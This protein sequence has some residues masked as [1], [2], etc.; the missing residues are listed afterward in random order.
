MAWSGLLRCR[1]CHLPLWLTWGHQTDA[2]RHRLTMTRNGNAITLPNAFTTRVHVGRLKEML[3]NTPQVNTM[4]MVHPSSMHL[5]LRYWLASGGIDPDR[6]LL[7]DYSPA[8]WWICKPE[9]L[10]VTVW[11]TWNLRGAIEGWLYRGLETRTPVLGVGKIKLIPTPHCWSS[12]AR[13]L[14]VLWMRTMGKKF[15]RCCPNGSM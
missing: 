5:L 10:M 4:G 7:E 6:R 1:P 3:H 11:G 8:Q 12:P 13:G 15:V 14:P 9:A 2:R